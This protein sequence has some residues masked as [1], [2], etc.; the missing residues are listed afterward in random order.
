MKVTLRLSQVRAMYG[1]DRARKTNLVDYGFRLPSAVDNRPLRFEEFEGMLG[2]A[3]YV[4]ATPA[5]Y[6]MEKSQGVIVQ[7]VIRP[8]GLLALVEYET[9]DTNQIDDLIEEIQQRDRKRRTDFSHYS[10]EKD[11]GRASKILGQSWYYVP[12]HSL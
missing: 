2:Q 4:S 1:G 9:I 3:I 10:Y 7:Q 12:I 8:T 5:D 11:G 6:E